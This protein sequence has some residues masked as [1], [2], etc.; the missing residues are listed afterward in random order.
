[1]LEI[2]H[3]QS[4]EVLRTVPMGLILGDG[5]EE[6]LLPTR[7]VPANASPGDRLEVFLYTD[8]E[9]RPIATCERPIA[10]AN[11]YAALRVVSVSQAGAFLDWGLPKDLL[12]PFRSQLRRPRP[13]EQVVVRVVC[14]VVSRRPVATARF[15]RFLEAPPESFREGQPVDLLVYEETDLGYKVVVDGCCGGLLYPEP[16]GPSAAVG[17]SA[18]GYI[19]RIREDGKVDLTLSP[20]GQAG[21]DVARDTLLGA[22]VAAGGRLELT[23]RS[24]SQAIRAQLGMSKKAFKR[25][26]GGLYRER[27]VRLEENCI[28]LVD[29]PS[30][31]DP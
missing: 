16:G 14:D 11:E 3:T 26:L 29:P 9:D 15:E 6:V 30:G 18:R 24:E 31:S 2:G 13:N 10:Q 17:D 27:R 20:G 12:L 4:L 25:A 23:D 5:D 28:E 1:M 19:Q 8:S 21:R 22:L 7:Q